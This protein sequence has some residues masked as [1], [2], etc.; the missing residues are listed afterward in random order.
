MEDFLWSRINEV[1]N[2]GEE[3][4]SSEVARV[5][6]ECKK[7]HER[8]GQYNEKSATWDHPNVGKQMN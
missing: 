3:V 6:K 5:F 7:A 4:S 8:K 2:S 1:M